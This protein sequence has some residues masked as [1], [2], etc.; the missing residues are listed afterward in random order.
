MLGEF[1]R[2]SFHQICLADA[3]RLARQVTLDGEL[4]GSA[5]DAFYHGAGGEVFEIHRLFVAV[6][7]GDF[8]ELCGRFFRIHGIQSLRDHRICRT[9]H[10]SAAQGFY[11]RL[12][13]GQVG[14]H[15]ARENGCC[16]FAVGAIY[17]DLDVE[18]AR[19][20]DGR[21][22]QVFTVGRSDDDHI[23][24]RLHAVYLGQQLGHDGGFHIGA[25]AR[26]SGAKQRLHLVKEHDHR[27]A[28]F[29]FLAGALED[30][31]YLAFRLAHI[32]VEQLGALDVEEVT[33]GFGVVGGFGQL[34][35]EGVGHCFGDEG[36]AAA[37]RPV[38]Q[39]AFGSRELVLH[40]EFGMQEGKLH[41]I[42][43]HLYLL[44]QPAYIF[45]AHI[46]HF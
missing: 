25:D 22:N 6:A 21:V 35:G 8:Q 1:P 5:H 23:A 9:V 11:L 44:L 7:I 16:C 34:L 17:L 12:G 28:F 43:D 14:G 13:D 24:Q 18:A 42:H 32:L 37:G 36:L 2:H 38:E 46:G 27:P 3:F 30:E 29:G 39:Y 20:Q 33:A 10:I 40:E 31:A 19:A 26:A 41:G 4:L 15:I 45:V